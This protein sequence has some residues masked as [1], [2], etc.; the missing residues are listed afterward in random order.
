MLYCS[1]AMAVIEG[2]SVFPARATVTGRSIAMVARR[3]LMRVYSAQSWTSVLCL[4]ATNAA[5]LNV[6]GP[7]M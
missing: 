3:G 6:S 1:G 4:T 7:A 5:L 2:G